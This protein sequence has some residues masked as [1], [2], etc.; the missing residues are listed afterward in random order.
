MGF[1]TSFVYRF[2]TNL[3][4]KSIGNQFNVA[5]VYGGESYRL[6]ELYFRESLFDE[7]FVFKAGRLNPGNDFIASPL[8]SVFVSNAFESN[9]VAIAINTTFSEDPFATWGSFLKF[10]PYQGL[11]FKFA[12]YNNNADI[13]D[14]KY[15]GVNFT[16]SSTQGV[17]LISE[18]AYL[19]NQSK[20]SHG[21][22]GNYKIGYYYVTGRVDKFAGGSQRGNYGYYLALD[23]MIY[24]IGNAKSERGISPFAAFLF[25]P[26][27]RNE[28]PFFVAAGVV[29]KGII[30]SRKDDSFSLGIAYGAYSSEMRKAQ[31]LAKKSGLLAPYGRNPQTAETVIELNYWLQ[32][33][34]WVAITPDIQYVINPRGYGTIQNALVIGLQLFM[35]I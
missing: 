12:L 33:T 7:R 19:V 18:W 27:D 31:G 11:V 3:S 2:G 15:H 24:R 35:E 14:N 17:M 8:Y 10:V 5:E 22:P 25:A 16:F 32:A 4:A 9:P 30:S 6:N 29:N 23:Q 1:F 13:F 34:K 28:F 26:K 21:M 20:L